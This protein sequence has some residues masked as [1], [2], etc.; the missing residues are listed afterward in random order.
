MYG[1]HGLASEI[2][3]GYVKI[4]T[5]RLGRLN[6]GI[7]RTRPMG[8]PVGGHGVAHHGTAMNGIGQASLETTF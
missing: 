2:D 3:S 7:L 5:D 1:R 6:N 4:M 8:R